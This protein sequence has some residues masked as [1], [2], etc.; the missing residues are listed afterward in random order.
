MRDDEQ[1]M[2]QLEKKYFGDISVVDVC[3]GLHISHIGEEQRH[4]SDAEWFAKLRLFQ[5]SWLP[6]GPWETAVY[7]LITV[8]LHERTVIG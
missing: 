5:N 8:T 2:R 4:P 6:E 1:T 3:Q 7:H